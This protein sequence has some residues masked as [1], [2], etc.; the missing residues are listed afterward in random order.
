MKYP[1]GLKKDI[2][3]DSFDIELSEP[4]MK[5]LLE[6]KSKFLADI[7]KQ[8]I[9]RKYKISFHKGMQMVFE[10]IICLILMISVTL[11]ANIFSLVYLIF[12]IKFITSEQKTHLMVR[13]VSYTSLCLFIQ[14][15]FFVVN[16]TDQ[17]SPILFPSQFYHFP[18]Y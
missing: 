4:P 8:A 15:M 12:I 6:Q 16:L 9:D 11:K 13:L 14:Y 17:S 5:I 18:K 10:N 2:T 7:L 1:E 3:I